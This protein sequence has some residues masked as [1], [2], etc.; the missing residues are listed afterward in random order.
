MVWEK[1]LT[2]GYYFDEL[3]TGAKLF[4]ARMDLQ[5]RV[6]AERRE[7]AEMDGAQLR[8]LGIT[9]EEA[10]EEAFRRDNDLPRNRLAEI[11]CR[12]SRMKPERHGAW[13]SRNNK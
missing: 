12:F 11:E 10:L 13:K 3:T 5:N 2:L 8:D 4:M 1:G 7:L 6:V 9:R